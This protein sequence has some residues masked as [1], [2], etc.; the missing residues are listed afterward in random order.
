MTTGDDQ[1]RRK[2]AQRRAREEAE[3]IA[4][5]VQRKA[6][7]PAVPSSLVYALQCPDSR[8]VRL[9]L[10]GLEVSV[11]LGPER[12]TRAEDVWAAVQQLT[13]ERDAP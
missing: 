9:G 6:R 1:L 12:E 10:G 8:T 5:E 11:V 3:R 2:Q 13:T 4:Q 7:G